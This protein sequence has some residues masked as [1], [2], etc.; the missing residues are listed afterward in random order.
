RDRTEIVAEVAPGRIERRP[1]E[2]RRDEDQKHNFG[3]Q[4]QL[5]KSGDGGEHG[6]AKDEQHRR[7]HDQPI[8]QE[9]ERRRYGQQ[10][11][12]ELERLHRTGVYGTGR[13]GQKNGVRLESLDEE[14]PTPA[15]HG[16]QY[17]VG[18]R[19]SAL[20]VLGV[21]VPASQPSTVAAAPRGSCALTGTPASG[22][23]VGAPSG[24]GQGFRD[25]ITA[26][27]VVWKTS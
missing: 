16:G 2:K 27:R 4:G 20:A 23:P 1:V 9:M 14:G 11:E 13:R 25:R 24:A 7:R 10:N 15:S 18:V 6:A 3:G 5:G 19:C 17:S 12:D 22:S 8:C 21:R 26:S